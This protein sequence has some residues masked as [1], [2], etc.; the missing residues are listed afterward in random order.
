MAQILNI[1]SIFKQYLWIMI[2]AWTFLTYLNNNL[3]ASGLL[4]CYQKY[5]LRANCRV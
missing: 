2:N 3:E 1:Q 4:E 5:Q